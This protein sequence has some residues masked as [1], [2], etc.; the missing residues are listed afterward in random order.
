MSRVD[1]LRRRDAADKAVLF[2]FDLLERDGQDFRGHPLEA[3]KQ[4]LASFF[5]VRG[6]AG[7]ILLCDHI[8]EDGPRVFEHA[9][10]L[11]AEGIV[12]KRLGRPSP[13]GRTESW[14]KVENPVE[15]QRERREN[16]NR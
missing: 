3:R 14:I 4:M 11:G 12:S 1:E 5:S 16:W 2:A 9:C 10:R 7:H 6:G 8:A 15:A 13:S